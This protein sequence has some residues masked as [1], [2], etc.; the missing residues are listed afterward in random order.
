MFS[1]YLFNIFYNSNMKEENGYY[2]ERHEN[3]HNMPNQKS[4]FHLISSI[5]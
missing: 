3:K 5:S 4:V 2:K 1:I